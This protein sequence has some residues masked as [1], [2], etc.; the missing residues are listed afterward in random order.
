MYKF[1]NTSYQR[2]VKNV[3]PKF[4]L[5]VH[6]VAVHYTFEKHYYLQFGCRCQQYEGTRNVN[7]LLSEF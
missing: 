1:L 5:E 4:D 3:D 6:N 7:N 2:S